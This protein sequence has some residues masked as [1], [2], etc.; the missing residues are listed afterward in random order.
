MRPWRA[1]DHTAVPWRTFPAHRMQ[2]HALFVHAAV[3]VL[4]AGGGAHRRRQRPDPAAADGLGVDIGTGCRAPARRAPRRRALASTRDLTK[5]LD[6]LTNGGFLGPDAT[7]TARAAAAASSSPTCTAPAATTSATRTQRPYQ[8]RPTPGTVAAAGAASRSPTSTSAPACSATCRRC[9]GSS[10]WSIDLRVDDLAQLAGLVVDPGRPGGARTS[11]TRS[12]RSRAPPARSSGQTVHRQ[13]RRGGLDARHAPPRRRGDASRCSTSIPTPPALKLEST[14]ATCRACSATENNG[15]RGQLGA[16]QPARHRPR[17]RPHRPGAGRST[18]GSTAPRRRTPRCSPA[19]RPP[20]L[21]EQISRGVRL[22]VW[23]DVSGDWHSLHLR[24]LHVEV[25]GAGRSSTTRRTTGSCRAPSLTAGRRAAGGAEE[26]PRGAGRLGRL[27]AVGAAAGHASSSTST[28]RSRSSTSRRPTPTPVN[29]VASRT[30][31]EPG[32]L[33]RLRYGRSYAFRAYAG[34]PGRQQPA[35]R[36]GRRSP[37]GD[38][39]RRAAGASRNRSP[40]LAAAALA[41]KPLGGDGAGRGGVGAGRPG[42]RAAGG[43]RPAAAA[44]RRSRR[45]ARRARA[46]A[47]REVEPTGVADVDRLVVSRLADRAARV[48]AAGPARR[49]RIEAAFDGAA[50]EAPHLLVRTDAQT[51]AP[52]YGRALATDVRTAAR[53][54]RAGA[55][56]RSSP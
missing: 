44:R 32:T 26:R 15:D 27:V 6:D 14:S 53:L 47:S 10:G 17:H 7:S 38:R 3:D 56:R 34:R 23:D 11:P 49:E 2:Q 46:R 43:A 51:P 31:I 1:P 55:R 20:L 21:Q 12:A 40:R 8:E 28:A 5:R 18:T 41:A 42:R 52:V 13:G 24:R 4:L 22:E 29:P 19:P 36:R 39:G 48:R 33:P 37:D 54:R 16:A 50:A 35:A 30:A 45:G 9:C 25:D